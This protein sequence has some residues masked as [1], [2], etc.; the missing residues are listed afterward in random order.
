MRESAP[1][2]ATGRIVPAEPPVTGKGRLR[3]LVGGCG[4]YRTIAYKNAKDILPPKLL[5]EIWEYIEGDT[6]YIPKR[7]EERAAWGSSNGTR[8][9]YELR[10]EE[11]RRRYAE[12]E[13]VEELAR[14]FCLSV[15]SIRKIL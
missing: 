8:R 12:N 5:S 9:E 14:K 4:R 11:I 3:L 13:S 10:N 15:E 2:L 7:G 1:A 6:L